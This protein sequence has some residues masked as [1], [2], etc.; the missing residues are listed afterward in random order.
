VAHWAPS[1][2][3]D[4][5]DTHEHECEQRPDTYEL[6]EDANWCQ[7]GHEREA[8]QRSHF[9]DRAQPGE[10]GRVDADGERIGDVESLIRHDAEQHDGDEETVFLCGL[11]GL[12][13]PGGVSQSDTL[14]A[15][16]W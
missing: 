16:P 6:T 13:V 2:Q 7:S 10:P 12:C 5:P 11:R 14:L 9:D 15:A 3:D 4:N 8:K 1:S